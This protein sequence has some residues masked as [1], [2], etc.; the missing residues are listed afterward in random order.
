MP[1]IYM[2]EED[3]SKIEGKVQEQMSK[4]Y[5]II[6]IESLGIDKTISV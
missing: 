3:A 2:T 1:K 4:L 6:I 5:S